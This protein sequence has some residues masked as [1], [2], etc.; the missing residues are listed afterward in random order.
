M[1]LTHKHPTHLFCSYAFQTYLWYNYELHRG[2]G[3]SGYHEPES[4][5]NHFRAGPDPLS[6]YTDCCKFLVLHP[7]KYMNKIISGVVHTARPG[8]GRVTAQIRVCLHL[9]WDGARSVRGVVS[10]STK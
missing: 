3:A 9:P 2:S 6:R 4:R 8:H 7:D 5:Q 1:P 10:L